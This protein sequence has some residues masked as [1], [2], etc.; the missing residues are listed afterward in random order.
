MT[1]RIR[2]RRA[3]AGLSILELMVAITIGLLMLAGLASLFATSSTSQNEV[4]RAAAQI[5]NGRYAMDTMTQ[6]LQVAGYF[7][8]YRSITA[9][10]SAP[11]PCA[12]SISALTTAIGLAVQG[13]HAG[14]LTATPNLSATTCPDSI[15]LNL[16]PGSDVLVVRRA[17]TAYVAINTTTAAGERYVQSNPVTIEVQNGGGTAT[18]CSSKADGSASTITRRCL[19]PTSLPDEICAGG[20]PTSPVG[21][22]RKLHVH[23]YFVSKCNV[24]ASGQTNCTSAADGGRPIPTLKRL[25]LAAE[26]GSATFQV[27]AIAEGVEFMTIGYGIDDTPS[28]VNAETGLIGDG[29]PDRYAL[30]PSLTDMT[31]AVTVRLDLLV[32]NPE[33]SANYT[34]A[35]T[36]KLGSAVGAPTSPAFTI[37]AADYDPT[38]RRHVYNSEIRLVNASSRKENP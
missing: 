16:S 37:T 35:K 21:Y 38:Y 23:I 22:I 24:A 11:D 30:D 4:R 5:E 20:C 15:K 12:T 1:P 13:Y 6:N 36:Y 8:L 7:G 29:A 9:P 14:S 34:D 19:S 2:K 18:T 32:R 26:A 31:N 28:A 27:T 3:Q 33:P 25:E 10:T 17:D